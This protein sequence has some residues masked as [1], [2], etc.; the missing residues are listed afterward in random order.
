MT[1]AQ[2]ALAAALASSGYVVATEVKFHATRKWRIDIAASRQD[3]TRKLAIEIDGG[4]WVNGRHT[5]GSGVLKDNEKIAYLAMDGWLFLR[6]TPQQ[7]K[8]GDALR[9]ATAVLHV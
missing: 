3:G 1:T 5:R 9:W 4:V 7:V 6:V 2:A 8:T